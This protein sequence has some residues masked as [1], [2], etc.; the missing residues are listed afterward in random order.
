MS[1]QWSK[2]SRHRHPNN[3]KDKKC[4]VCKKII[5]HDRLNQRREIITCCRACSVDYGRLRGRKSG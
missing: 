3:K 1:H 5:N 2:L 4:L